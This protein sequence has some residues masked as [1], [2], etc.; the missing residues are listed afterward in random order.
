MLFILFS[1]FFFIFLYSLMNFNN[2]FWFFFYMSMI[3]VVFFL[4]N[5]ADGFS[6]YVNSFFP[7]TVDFL[8]FILV[9]LSLFIVLL[10]LISGFNHVKNYFSFYIIM[11]LLLMLSMS[12]FF[13]VSNIFIFFFF[14]EAT[15]LP[16]MIVIGVWGGNKE[17]LLSNYYFVLYTLVGGLPF[18]VFVLFFFMKGFYSF[19][20]LYCFD[21]F[22]ITF[23]CFFLIIFGFLCKLP[24]YGVHLW[25]PK[26]HVEAPVGG[27]MVLAGLMLK[28][29]G[30]GFLRFGSFIV[31]FYGFLFYFLV[32]VVLFGASLALLL[33]SKQVDIKS[34]IAYSSVSHMSLLVGG[35]LLGGLFGLKGVV[36]MMVGHGITSPLMFF[37]ANLIYERVQSRMYFSFMGLQ[38]FFKLFSLFLFFSLLFNMGFPPF[39]NFWGEL[40]IILGVLNFSLFFLPFVFLFF[41][42]G[43]VVMIQLFL[44]MSRNHGFNFNYGVSLYMREAQMALFL[45][46]YL[47]FFTA[48]L[49]IF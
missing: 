24:I 31:F 7:I 16:M 3:L 15:V 9:F 25:L 32:F 20:L 38:R 42:L 33:C 23:F 47:G 44:K 37:T 10:S 5:F 19:L 49:F 39:L 1:V 17:R 8:S 48:L 27:S 13:T 12:V 26:A 30:Y 35:G 28:M 22:I 34:F 43:G 14:F 40:L 4:K 18:L 2:N 11:F 45:I 6:K 21:F 29:G 41:L 36:I 46:F